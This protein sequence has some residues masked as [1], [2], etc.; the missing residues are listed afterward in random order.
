MEQFCKDLIEFLKS[1]YDDTF[2]FDITTYSDISGLRD[3]ELKIE[4]SNSYT[5]IINGS[6]MD[7]IYRLYKTGHYYSLRKEFAWQKELIDIIEG[8]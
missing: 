4:M 3:I 5:K 8:S 7:G 1:Q 6:V 2:C